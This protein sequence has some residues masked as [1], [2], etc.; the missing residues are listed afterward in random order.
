M[1]RSRLQSL[2][3]VALV[4]AATCVLSLIRIPAP[5]PFT[6]QTFGVF[7]ALLF[8]GAKQGSAA[9]LLYLALGLVGLPVFSGGTGASALVGPTGGYLVGLLLLCLVFL[10]FENKNR[11]LCALFGM[12]L[13]YL[14][15]ASW[16]AF[17]TS[18]SLF[19]ALWV[20]AVPFL[21]P[22]ALKYLLAHLLC[23]RLKTA[24]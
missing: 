14:C 6:L 21:L 7:F 12:A 2:L 15:G 18:T 4:A 9:T 19:F 1:M 5:V 11:H 20:G 10:L 23:R 8:L 24:L 22:D 17:V 16:Y 3:R 13:C